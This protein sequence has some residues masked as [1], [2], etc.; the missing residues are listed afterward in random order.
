MLWDVPNPHQ[1]GG[2]NIP[3]A[4]GLAVLFLVFA[5]SLVVGG[6]SPPP[7]SVRPTMAGLVGVRRHPRLPT[8]SS[9]AGRDPAR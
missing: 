1:V 4:I 9:L 2:I 7:D 3:A 5:A 8:S 6:N